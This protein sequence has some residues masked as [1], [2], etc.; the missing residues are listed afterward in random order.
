MR[1]RG[2]AY[3]LCR[4]RTC[5]V[6]ACRE[7]LSLGAMEEPT[8]CYVILMENDPWD[9]SHLNNQLSAPSV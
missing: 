7:G 3:L 1:G 2:A 8:L 4:L 9:R 5:R 6:T